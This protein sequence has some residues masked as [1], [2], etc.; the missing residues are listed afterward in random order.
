[1]RR[2]VLGAIRTPLLIQVELSKSG[3]GL[4]MSFITNAAAK[5]ASLLSRGAA[6]DLSHGRQPVGRCRFEGSPVGAKESQESVAPTGLIV[7]FG[8]KPRAYARGF[9]LSPLRGSKGDYSGP[10]IQMDMPS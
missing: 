4:E 5:A 1:M 8:R 9:D 10:Q 7:S 6:T 3:M 2:S